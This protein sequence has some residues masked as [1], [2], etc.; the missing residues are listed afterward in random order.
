MV[1]G[2][3]A[4]AAVPDVIVAAD[5]VEALELRRAY[6]PPAARTARQ[7]ATATEATALVI[8]RKERV[9]S[10]GDEDIR[11]IPFRDS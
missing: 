9:L 3:T 1:S 2:E 7:I 5:S 11:H 10:G 6:A 8:E 4:R